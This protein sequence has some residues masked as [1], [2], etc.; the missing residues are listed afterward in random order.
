MPHV[1]SA[2][3]HFS[4]IDFN[5]DSKKDD[6]EQEDLTAKLEDVMVASMRETESK[7]QPMMVNQEIQIDLNELES[8]QKAILNEN[9]EDKI[10]PNSF[11]ADIAS[12]LALEIELEMEEEEKRENDEKE[13]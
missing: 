10:Q 11:Y 6:S 9:V 7:Q 4:P 12:K 8:Y 3:S 13:R 5:S 2:E 1:E